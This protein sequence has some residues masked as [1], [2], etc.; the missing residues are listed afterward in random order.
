MRR[1]LAEARAAGAEGEVPIGC[2]VVDG[3]KLV[4]RAHNLRETLR[5]PTAHAEML[6]LTQAAESRG[7]WRL[8]GCTLYATLEPCAMCAGAIL[9]G[10]VGRVVFGADDPQVGACG[11]VLDLGRDPRFAPGFETAGGVESGACRDLL[12]GFFRE[13]RRRAP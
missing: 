12:K 5:D 6:A 7:D 8:D 1:A 2:V 13:R 3:G 10:R 9:A 11:S 4:A